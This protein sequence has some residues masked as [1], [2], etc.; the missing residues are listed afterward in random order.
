[1]NKILKTNIYMVKN[2]YLVKTSKWWIFWKD[3]F[4][5]NMLINFKNEILIYIKCLLR[6]LHGIKLKFKNLYE[7]TKKKAK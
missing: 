5:T 1:M 6:F 2:N 4:F 7:N 3:S